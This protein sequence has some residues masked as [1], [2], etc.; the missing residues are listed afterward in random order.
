MDDIPT[1]EDLRGTVLSAGNYNY[2]PVDTAVELWS[3]CAFENY[4]QIKFERFSSINN[5]HFRCW[6][7]Q[8]LAILCT[9]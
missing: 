8:I 1:E 7:A 2:T 6:K 4:I 5:G 3:M 9:H